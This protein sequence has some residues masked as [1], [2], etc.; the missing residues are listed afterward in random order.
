M[1]HDMSH[2][3]Q[4]GDIHVGENVGDINVG[5]RI[6]NALKTVYFNGKSL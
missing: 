2:N 4:Y 3:Q 6:L 5:D 1:C